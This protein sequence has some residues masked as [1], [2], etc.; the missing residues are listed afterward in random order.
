MTEQPEQPGG[1]V[2]DQ[3]PVPLRDDTDQEPVQ[4][5]APGDD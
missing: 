5:E 1:G 2:A 3:E 4:E